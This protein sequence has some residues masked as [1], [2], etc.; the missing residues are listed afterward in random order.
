MKAAWYFLEPVDPKALNIPDYTDYIKSPMDLK[1]ISEKMQQ[2]AYGSHYQQFVRDVRQIFMNAVIYNEPSTD[3]YHCAVIMSNAFEKTLQK[4][5]IPVPFPLGL[6][7]STRW[8]GTPLGWKRVDK[9]AL[10]QSL[11]RR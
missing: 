10:P 8:I 5:S 2:K 4:Y 3:V 9:Y 7:R 1:T 6:G 11:E